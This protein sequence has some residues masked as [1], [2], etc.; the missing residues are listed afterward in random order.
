MSVYNVYNVTSAE[1]N[2]L[3]GVSQNAF[4][5]R[6]EWTL[7]AVPENPED[8]WH[9]CSHLEN[10]PFGTALDHLFSHLSARHMALVLTWLSLT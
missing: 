7:C 2:V 3:N 4:L 1:W 10:T 5:E 9:T 6:S 8:A